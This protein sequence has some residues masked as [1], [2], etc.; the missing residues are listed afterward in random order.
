LALSRT[1]KTPQPLLHGSIFNRGELSKEANVTVNWSKDV[2]QT[3]VQAKKEERP[4]LVDF[5]AAPA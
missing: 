1:R 2:D 5:S 4:I 3:L